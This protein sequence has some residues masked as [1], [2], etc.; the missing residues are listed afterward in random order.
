MRYTARSRISVR[1]G[2]TPFVSV[3]SVDVELFD[4]FVQS[5]NRF[6]MFVVFFHYHR[7]HF[8]AFG[9]SQDL[10]SIDIFNFK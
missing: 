8:S 4:P 7:S 10:C 1:I 9:N 6:D 5:I 3:R 2:G